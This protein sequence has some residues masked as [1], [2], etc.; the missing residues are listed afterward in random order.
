LE[1]FTHKC[2]WGAR[3]G[4]VRGFDTGPLKPNFQK[5]LLV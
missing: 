2:T 4:G 1:C 5:N 3:G